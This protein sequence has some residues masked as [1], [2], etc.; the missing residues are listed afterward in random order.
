MDK[1]NLFLYFLIYF[2]C[3][4]LPNSQRYEKLLQIFQY[5]YY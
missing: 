2:D 5:K 1:A 3:Q 4:Y